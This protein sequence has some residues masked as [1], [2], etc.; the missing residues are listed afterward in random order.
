MMPL[1]A[2][3]HSTMVSVV[4][5]AA[6]ALAAALPVS[7]RPATVLAI[8]QP[9]SVPPQEMAVALQALAST[10]SVLTM[11]PALREVGRPHST[12]ARMHRRH[13]VT[14]AR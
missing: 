2:R 1:P 5:P 7:S 3:Q 6:S 4:S 14:A 8:R 13:V 11:Q 12:R 10:L 9:C